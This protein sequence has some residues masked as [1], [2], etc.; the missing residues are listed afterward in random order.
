M[1][2]ID[3]SR[4]MVCKYDSMGKICKKGVTAKIHWEV[5][6]SISGI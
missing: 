4:L 1:H 5:F 3:A 6:V 2:K